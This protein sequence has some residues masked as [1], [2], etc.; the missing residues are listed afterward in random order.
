MT[1]TVSAGGV[2]IGGGNPVVVQSMTNTPTADVRA[3]VEQVRR[4]QAS[5]CEVVR[6]AVPDRPAA[7]AIRELKR[8]VTVPLVADIHYDH[9]LALAALAAGV[10]KLRLNPGNIRDP[11]KI[12]AIAR[13]AGERGVPIRVGVN[14]GSVDRRFL[15]PRGEVTAEGL[16]DAALWEVELLERAGFREVVVAIKAHDVPLT[17]EANRL[18]RREGDW[19]VHLGV[20]EAGTEW[21]GAIRSAVGIGILLA[22]G[23]GDTLRVSLAGDPV[24]EVEAAWEILAALGLR[25]RGP[26]YVV[27]PTCGRTGI[28]VPGITRAVRAGLAHLVQPLTVAIMGCPV[29][30]VGEA[31]RADFAILGGKGFGTLYAHGQV[32]QPKVPEERLVA[33]LVALVLQEVGEHA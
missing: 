26:S 33:E 29:N 11:E 21:E 1:R 10:D 12:V 22:E 23:I 24:R 3:T 20:T 8:E 16:V 17:V 25:R 28:D 32:V 5:G 9:R 15:G 7:E 27:C 2:A 13:A 4:L 6:V 19:P 14:A 30:G 18:L 31:E